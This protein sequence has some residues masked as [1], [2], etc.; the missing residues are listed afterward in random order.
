MN[1][2]FGDT[3]AMILPS[4]NSF[5]ESIKYLSEN[6]ADFKYNVNVAVQFI[7]QII[8]ELEADDNATIKMNSENNL[9]SVTNYH[10]RQI[11]NKDRQTCEQI[12]QGIQTM[13]NRKNQVERYFEIVD[14]KLQFAIKKK[15]MKSE[16]IILAA[17]KEHEH[18]I[19]NLQLDT[20]SCSSKIESIKKN[21]EMEKNKLIQLRNYFKTKKTQ[22]IRTYDSEMMEKYRK[23]NEL[24]SKIKN[25]EENICQLQVSIS[26]QVP[27]YN[28]V[29]REKEEENDRIWH[30][31]LY[32]I[33]RK[34]AARK[35]Q[36]NFRRYLN[37]IKTRDIKKNKK[38]Q[39]KSQSKMKNN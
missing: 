1:I 5:I 22:L 10:K 4:L 23:V 35:I 36:L 8:E 26:D 39:K 24:N 13:I 3:R 21:N 28:D 33:Q 14:R 9:C 20:K 7:T 11:L 2:Y 32:Q 16:A 29:I 25:I 17:M 30:E 6:S 37:Y 18:K 19:L 31:K 38:G 12:K 27:F 15:I 34:I